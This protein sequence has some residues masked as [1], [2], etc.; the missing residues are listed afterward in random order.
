MKKY[1]AFAKNCIG[2]TH[3]HKGIVCQDASISVNS[4]KYALAAVA[5]GHGSAWYLRT[6]IGSRLC[7]EC[8]RD[9]VDEF[10]C[11]LDNAS[12]RLSTEKER[13]LL[14]T[15]LWRSIVSRWH[16]CVEE[17]CRANPFT[18]EEL[19][20]I[21]E[22]KSHYRAKYIGGDFLG[23]YG[24]TLLVAVVTEEF[25][26][27]MQ[28]GDG[29]CVAI[30]GSAEVS[31]PVPF[32]ERCYGCVTT[33]M[34]QDDAVQSGRY[35]Y[36]PKESIP[37][38]IFLGTDGVDDSYGSFIY[39]HNF[40]RGLALTF[41]R[42]GNEDA[43][44]QLEEFLPKLTRNGNGDDVSVAGII[45]PEALKLA[46]SVFAEAAL[47]NSAVNT[48]LEVRIRKEAAVRE[49]TDKAPPETV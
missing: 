42:S 6:E 43:L 18:E 7:V 30:N 29:T 19:A 40:Y 46:E 24:T 49:E 32:D 23:A 28:I 5:D 37:V 33:S 3:I 38:A 11:S 48:E 39:L 17:H 47:E 14:L 36:F 45:F 16:D 10:L 44:M 41:A 2:D 31:E 12:E 1:F 13:D 4:E 34:C 27:C 35:C 25:A 26:F 8:A 22:D 15:Q 9:C 20:K 21:P